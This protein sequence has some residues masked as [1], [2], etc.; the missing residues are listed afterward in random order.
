MRI[1]STSPPGLARCRAD[2][3]EERALLLEVR[4]ERLDDRSDLDEDPADRLGVVRR[5][6]P[7]R[8]VQLVKVVEGV[9]LRRGLVREQSLE[10]DPRLRLRRANEAE[11]LPDRVAIGPSRK[12]RDS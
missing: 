10:V 2:G 11:I 12:V 9:L 6:R 3:N 1:G 5:D 7:E 4:E 8:V